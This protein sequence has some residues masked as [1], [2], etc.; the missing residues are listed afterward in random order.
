M[1]TLYISMYLPVGGVSTLAGTA[2]V[3]VAVEGG[4]E[5]PLDRGLLD[6]SLKSVFR[7]NSIS[8]SRSEPRTCFPECV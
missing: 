1:K 2:S 4:A 6:I 3:V 5:V 8:I 7:S